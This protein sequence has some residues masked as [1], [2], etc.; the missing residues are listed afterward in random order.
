M[1]EK[2]RNHSLTQTMNPYEK[3]PIGDKAPETVRV[4]IENQR[5]GHNKYE[6]DEKLGL[7]KLDRVLYS[8]VH[9]PLDY[10]FIPETRSEDGDHLDAFVIGGDPVF[11]GCVVDAR[12][13][14]LVEMIDSGEQDNK[15][16]AVQDKNP[17]FKEIKDLADVEKFNPHLIKELVNFLETYKI[18]Q[19]KEVKVSAVK[20]AEAAKAEIRRAME[21]ER[22]K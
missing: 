9:F 4:I 21:A 14:A 5:G 6:Y 3:L 15:I 12:P 13:I 20:D 8:S 1:A 16:I 7:F 2:G 10:G 17:R 18:L 22:K 19:G 11:Q